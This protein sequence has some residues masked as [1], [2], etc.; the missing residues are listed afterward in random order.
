MDAH[1]GLIYFQAIYLDIL[2]THNDKW[3]PDFTVLCWTDKKKT[4]TR[5]QYRLKWQMDREW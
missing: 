3:H 4:T 5:Q 2:P 1:E